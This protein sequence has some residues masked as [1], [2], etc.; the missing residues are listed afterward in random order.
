MENFNNIPNSG[1]YGAAIA[2][3]NA[4][5]QL[6]KEQLERLEYS[7]EGFCGMYDN[8]SALQA[9]YP[10]PTEG[11]FA[12]V[13]T[14]F[15]MSVY[16]T[17]GGIWYDSGQTYDGGGIDLTQY[18]KASDLSALQ[19]VVNSLR[20]SGYVFG[21]VASPSFM[22]DVISGIAKFY[23]AWVAGNYSRYGGYT[24]NEGELAILA[25]NG[26]TWVN[27]KTNIIAKDVASSAYDDEPTEGSN[28]LLSSGT[29][30]DAINETKQELEDEMDGI[31]PSFQS[32]ENISDVLISQELGDNTWSIPSQKAVKDAV[33]NMIDVADIDDMDY[34][35]LAPFRTANT[36]VR[37]TVTNTVQ[38]VKYKVGVLD[39]FSDSSGHVLTQVF[40]SHYAIINGQIDTTQHNDNVVCQYYRSVK[41]NGGTLPTDVGVWTSWKVMNN[42]II[43]QLQSS[44]SEIQQKVDYTET[45]INN[46]TSL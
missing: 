13:G 23:I 46:I 28:K 1:T 44:I 22:P 45:I 42:S 41:I 43:N 35:S 10:S 38:S 25:Y 2:L 37:F 19:S 31:N 21:G 36:Q 17:N 14:T 33:F 32:G 20:T 16:K 26:S 12:Y 39:V 3:I 4:N 8:Q 27:S 30:F 34:S 18:A 6:T 40:T 11:S 24:V 29:I 7:R 5:F 15:P 9:A